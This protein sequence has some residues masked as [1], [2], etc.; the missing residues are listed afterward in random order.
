MCEHSIAINSGLWFLGRLL[1]SWLLGQHRVLI[2]DFA[3]RRVLLVL[4]EVV[5]V[6]LDLG[7]QVV[8]VVFQRRHF[9]VNDPVRL[10]DFVLRVLDVLLV[11]LDPVDVEQVVFFERHE[12][13]VQL[14]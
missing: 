5:L 7:Q 4:F 9:V 1:R 12:F 14:V 13:L 11:L 8:L 6:F 10:V 2:H 3:S